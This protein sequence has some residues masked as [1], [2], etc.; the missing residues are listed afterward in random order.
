[1]STG[2]RRKVIFPGRRVATA[3]IVKRILPYLKEDKADMS[4][5]SSMHLPM[6]LRQETP[7]IAEELDTESSE[8]Q[9][10][11]AEECLPLLKR[12]FPPSLNK[13]KHVSFLSS[14]LGRLP[15]GY[16]ALDASRPW[17]LYWAISA[18]GA[19]GEDLKDLR[20]K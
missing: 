4:S 6:W 14:C 10:E 20:E 15:A 17:M 12:V 1:M 16:A 2:N 8:L 3:S 18:F 5:M 11:T 9:I 13:A 7:L 19:L